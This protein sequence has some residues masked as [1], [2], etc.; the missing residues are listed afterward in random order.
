MLLGIRRQFDLLEAERGKMS[1]ANGML[2]SF[3]FAEAQ[4]RRLDG[5]T[6]WLAGWLRANL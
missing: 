2:N 5:Q 4:G 1:L 3:R 6:D